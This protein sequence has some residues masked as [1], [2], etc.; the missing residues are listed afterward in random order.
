[1][2]NGVKHYRSD[3]DGLRA[4]AV[5]LVLIFHF[6]LIPALAAGFTGVDIFFV[7]SGFLI[8][9]I[10]L[11]QLER[12]EFKITEFYVARIRRLAPA[13]LATLACT[14]I[15]GLFVL[16]PHDLRELARQLVAAQV[17]VANIY[18][19]RTVNYF[20][21]GSEDVFL[22]HM[23]SLAV[24]EQFY[25]I[26][27]IAL[28]FLWRVAPR[29][30][31]HWIAVTLLASLLLNI[32]FIARKPEAVFYLLPTRAWELLVGA[33]VVFFARKVRPSRTADQWIASTGLL[34][35]VAGATLYKPDM[36]FPGVFAVI[37]TLGAAFI[38]FSHDSRPTVVARMLEWP[39]LGYIGRISYPLYLVHWP[40]HVFAARLLGERYDWSAH[41]VMFVV[42]IILAGLIYHLIELPI[43][44]RRKF[45][46]RRSLVTGYTI[47]MA[48]TL[49]VVTVTVATDGLPARFPADVVRLANFVDDKTPMLSECEFSA[50]G[51]GRGLHQP[52]RIGEPDI[53]PRWLIVGD[54]HAWAMH[55]AFDLWLK[56]RKEAAYFMFRH[57]CPPL[58]TVHLFN[59]DGSC[60]K[61]NDALADLAS[62]TPTIDSVV[63][64]STWRQGR[65]R[66]I[67]VGEDVQPTDTQSRALFAQGFAAQIQRL[68]GIGKAVY[69][70]EPLPGAKANVPL[71]MA[72]AA[73]HGDQPS[74]N[75]SRREYLDEYDYFFADLKNNTTK[76]DGVFSSAAV[77]CA[78]G[79]CMTSANG[80]P[81]Y[82]DNSHPT[83]S[84][85]AFFAGILEQTR[86]GAGRT[87]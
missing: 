72:R 1:M 22:L 32:A 42:S 48:A 82:F 23:W 9:G 40:I 46:G 71:A 73:L 74:V 62:R 85:A 39:P 34:C 67:S 33:A 12:D 70:W 65:E 6:S 16:F 47:A 45:A 44:E 55:D 37:P 7:I 56:D 58:A 36:H 5:L 24:E 13:L 54:S 29:K 38:L 87:N 77:L 52:C 80:S 28:V 17:Y 8:T 59:D 66:L 31:W 35:I 49:A 21:L 18:F 83:R 81:L 2:T 43:R 84:S 79:Y 78:S 68:K 61:F 19:W 41:A 11:R 3:I 60:F 64:V 25:L 14:F 27:P 63:L 57:G 30:I 50:S 20:G 75:K 4:I 51:D 15:F 53:A 86:V 10:L 69:V 76:I 26:Y